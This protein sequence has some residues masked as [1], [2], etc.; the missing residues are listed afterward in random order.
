MLGIGYG[1]AGLAVEFNSREMIFDCS[2]KKRV[3]RLRLAMIAKIT[4]HLG[5]ESVLE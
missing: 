1:S 3:Y 4:S 2:G 5:I